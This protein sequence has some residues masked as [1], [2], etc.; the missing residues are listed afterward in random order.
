MKYLVLSIASILSLAIN[1]QKNVEL[2]DIYKKFTFYATGVQGINSM[3]DGAN[4]TTLEG[5]KV[6]KYSYETGE[7]VEEILSSN[8]IKEKTGV[9]IKFSGYSFSSDETKVLLTTEEEK[10]YRYSTRAIFYVYDLTQGTLVKVDDEKIRYAT[11]SPNGD[12]LA[13]VKENNLFVKDLSSGNTSQI[14][15]DGKSNEII[16]GATDWVYEEELKI[17]KAFFWSPKGDY[18]AFYRFDETNVPEFSMDIYGNSLYPE[19]EVF[20]YPK[21]GEENSK[22][23]IHIYNLTDGSTKQAL[24]GVDY[25][26]VPRIVWTKT[27][28]EFVAF[29]LNR[30]QNQLVLNRVNCATA[31]SGV[32]YK[33]T[34]EAYIEITDDIRF[35]NDGSFI[36]SSEM[37]GYNHLYHIDKKGKIKRQLTSGNWDV[38]EFYGIDEESNTLFFQAAKEHS[39]ERNVYSISLKG[40]KMNRL[41]VKNGVNQAEFSKGFKY[42]INTHSAFNSPPFVSLHNSDGK[43]IRTIKDNQKIV[44]RI[45]NHNMVEREFFSIKVDENIELPAWKMLPL[46]FDENKKYPVLM[47]VYGGPGSQKVMNEYNAFNDV[48]YQVLA[49]NGYIIVCVDN[50]GTGGKGRDFKKVTYKE[51]GKFEVEDQIASA[52]YLG[53]LNYVDADRIGIWGWSYGGFMSSNCLFK[54]KDVFKAAIAVAPVTNWRFYDNIYTE[55][56]MQTPQENANGYDMNSPINHVKGLKGKYL[57]VHGSAD[58]NVHVQNT[59]RMVNELV[60]YNK[61]FDFFIYPDRDHSILGGGA[62]KHLYQKMTDFILQNL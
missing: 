1:A 32:L 46:D 13:F 3:N 15:Y 30:H 28:E 8:S 7:K 19:Q 14:T 56:Y 11:F 55:R 26:Y 57:L 16:N 49:S 59:M 9:T 62:R 18:I 61:Q 37:S 20:K 43:E 5:N 25:E 12:K 38:I 45:E 24:K 53:S 33:E 27:N 54:G 41:S 58:D 42:Y 4:F 10:I 60:R 52:K 2:D 44:T 50:R 23:T 51:L 6:V 29:T 21:A 22:V 47:F 17:Y 31:E 48:W 39:Y 35:L 40:K 34:D 36:W